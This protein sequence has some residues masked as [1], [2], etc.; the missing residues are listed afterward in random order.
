MGCTSSAALHHAPLCPALKCKQAN[1]KLAKKL[2]EQLTTQRVRA[3]SAHSPAATRHLTQCRGPALLPLWAMRTA[4]YLPSAPP[5]HSP[6]ADAVATAATLQQR[7]QRGAPEEG[8]APQT[9]VRVGGGDVAVS[10]SAPAAPRRMARPRSAASLVP[11]TLGLAKCSGCG[12]RGFHR[13]DGVHLEP[14]RHCKQVGVRAPRRAR[15]HV[16]RVRAAAQQPGAQPGVAACWLLQVWYC[17]EVCAKADWLSHKALCK[18]QTTGHW[19]PFGR[20]AEQE[21]WVVSACVG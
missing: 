12:A 18:W 3:H 20:K 11:K 16:T 14:C 5:M 17:S 1:C 6:F 9:T 13:A 2:V 19:E 7:Q 4:L 10:P 8:E 15:R 21:H